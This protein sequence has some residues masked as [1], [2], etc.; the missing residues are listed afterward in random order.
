MSSP[1]DTLSLLLSLIG[2]LQE[3]YRLPSSSPCTSSSP[4]DC[5]VFSGATICYSPSRYRSPCISWSYRSPSSTVAIE[6]S[7]DPPRPVVPEPA[8]T[9]RGIPVDDIEFNVSFPLPLQC[10]PCRSGNYKTFYWLDDWL[11]N[12]YIVT[13]DHCTIVN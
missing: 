4:T 9:D 7:T 11:L 8:V 5:W 1:H 3:E 2:E 6:L 10:P 12:C 13:L